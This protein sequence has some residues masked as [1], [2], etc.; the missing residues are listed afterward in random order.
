MVRFQGG[1]AHD[2]ACRLWKDESP[3]QYKAR[4][5]AE[6]RA[7]KLSRSAKTSGAK[8]FEAGEDNSGE[9]EN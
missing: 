3:T 6:R 9:E 1:T 5:A 8:H 7:S 4:R 2:K